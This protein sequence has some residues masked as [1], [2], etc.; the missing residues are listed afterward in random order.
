VTKTR[1]N[2]EIKIWRDYEEKLGGKRTS[3]KN[4]GGKRNEDK[5]EKNLKYATLISNAIPK[6]SVPKCRYGYGPK[7]YNLPAYNYDKFT[8]G[9]GDVNPDKAK[10][11]LLFDA[12][13][14]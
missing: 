8:N 6:C 4:L 12:I 11:C 2:D 10:N 14:S 9:Y 3:L 7:I 5:D 13:I 1:K